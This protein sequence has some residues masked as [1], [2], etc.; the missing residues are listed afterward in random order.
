[1][2]LTRI[3][4]RRGKP[5]AYR[6][7]IMTNVYESMREVFTVP[8]DDYFMVLTEHDA[9]NFMFPAK[10]LGMEHSENFVLIQI[11]CNNTRNLDQKKALY[12]RI[13]DR[14][15]GDPGITPNDVLINLVEVV[16]E[17]WS[18]GNGLASFA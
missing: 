13:V 8:E 1:M 14:L 7:A 4:V 11:T 2:P 15:Q 6:K 10:F 12:K 5:D 9:T 18:M 17:N 3:S 16:K